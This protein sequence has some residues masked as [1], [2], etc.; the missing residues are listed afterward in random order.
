VLASRDGRQLALLIWHYHDDDVPGA[1]AAVEL[2]IGG[3]PWKKNARIW[4]FR[5]DAE[6]S[7]AFA[8]WRR[9]GSPAI[10]D[11]A[12][13][14]TLRAAGQLTSLQESH[15]EPVNAGNLRLSFAL[16]RQAVS[17]L[18]ISGARDR[19]ILPPGL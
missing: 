2:S 4:H 17:M 5:I 7:N 6:H 12:E 18:I 9:I 10:L 15:L 11:P 19:Q 3:L 16:P 13:W 8:A 1:D 14:N